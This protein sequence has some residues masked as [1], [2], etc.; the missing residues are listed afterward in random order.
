MK[1]KK[2]EKPNRPSVLVQMKLEI[3]EKLK[4]IA[5]EESISMSSIIEQLIENEWKE[6]N[7]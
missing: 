3:K 1:F 7:K 5:E 4:Q 6:R 2:P